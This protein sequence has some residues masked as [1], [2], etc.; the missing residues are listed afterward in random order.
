MFNSEYIN[1]RQRTLPRASFYTAMKQGGKVVPLVS[2]DYAKRNIF[3]R[4]LYQFTFL[5]ERNFLDKC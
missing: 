4:I 5:P 2:H 1:K 3:F